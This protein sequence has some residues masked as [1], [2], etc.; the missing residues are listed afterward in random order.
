MS[1]PGFSTCPLEIQRTKQLVGVETLQHGKSVQQPSKTEAS[2][3]I[4]YYF[5]IIVQR[6]KE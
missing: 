5:D 3:L 6:K 2:V 4:S 1:S